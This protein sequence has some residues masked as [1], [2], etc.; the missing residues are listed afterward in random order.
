[1]AQYVSTKY[2]ALCTGS[3]AYLEKNYGSLKAASRAAG[4]SDGVL[5]TACTKYGYVWGKCKASPDRLTKKNLKKL[6]VDDGL[7]ISELAFKMKMP[8]DVVTA[9]IDEHGL[10]PRD[11]GTLNMAQLLARQSWN[12]E[13]VLC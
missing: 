4:C 1:M 6:Y 11:E 13:L 8:I 3:L 2:E 7:T 9:A 10:R 5:R 12:A